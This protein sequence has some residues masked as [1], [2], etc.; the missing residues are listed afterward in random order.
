MYCLRIIIYKLFASKLILSL[1]FSYIFKDYLN[2]PPPPPCVIREILSLV[3]VTWVNNASRTLDLGIIRADIPSARPTASHTLPLWTTTLIPI[4]I[5]PISS[6]SKKGVPYK[7]GLKNVLECPL[8]I[9]K[10]LG[11]GISHDS[12]LKYCVVI[13]QL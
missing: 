11:N 2:S 6:Q 3:G 7:D 4:R 8:V 9:D 1:K 5:K 10:G 13:T 12:Q